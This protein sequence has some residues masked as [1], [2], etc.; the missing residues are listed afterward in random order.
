MYRVGVDEHSQDQLD[1]LP[2][3][4]LKAWRELHVV[5]GVSRLSTKPPESAVSP[6]AV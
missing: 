2:L 6:A 3:E 5:L 4:G 1:A